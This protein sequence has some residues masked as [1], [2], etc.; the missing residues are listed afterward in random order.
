MASPAGE[1]PTPTLPD[2]LL[3]EILIL[4]PALADLGRACVACSAFRRVIT[5]PS[6]LRRLHALHPPSLLGF[7]PSTGGFHPAVVPGPSA[8]RALAAAA[9]FAFSFLPEPGPWLVRDARGGRFVLDRIRG[10]DET[11]TTIAICDPLFGATCSFLLSLRTWPPA[12]SNRTR[13]MAGADAISSS[14]LAARRRR[15]R[16][17]RSG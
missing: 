6:F 1:S 11:F 4:L 2:E 14:L 9:D 16:R 13:S 5:D 15:G 8:A 10:E 12:S 7:V 17:I 3:A